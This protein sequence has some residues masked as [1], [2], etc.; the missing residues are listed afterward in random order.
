MNRFLFEVTSYYQ[1]QLSTNRTF[2]PDKETA[3]KQVTEKWVKGVEI[4][5]VE[6]ASFIPAKRGISEVK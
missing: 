5:R 4:I 1:G 3:I 6:Q 2:A